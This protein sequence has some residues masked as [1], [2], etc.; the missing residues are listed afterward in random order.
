MTVAAAAPVIPH[1]KPKIN[2][3]SRTVLVTAPATVDII[4]KRGE[5]PARITGFIACPNI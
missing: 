3:G 5:P 1:R 2:S 4:A